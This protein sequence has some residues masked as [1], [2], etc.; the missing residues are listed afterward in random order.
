[1]KR[2]FVGA[3]VL[4]LLAIILIPAWLDGS[5]RRLRDENAFVP[6]QPPADSRKPMVDPEEIGEQLNTGIPKLQQLPKSNPLPIEKQ[7][8][9]AVAASTEKVIPAQAIPVVPVADVVPE[10]IEVDLNA[11]A[12]GGSVAPVE[13]PKN[14]IPV[15]TLQSANWIVQVGSFASRENAES[16]VNRLQKGDLKA[17]MRVFKSKNLSSQTGADKNTTRAV[18]DLYSPL[19]FQVQ[20]GRW[21]LVVK[22]D[23][24][25]QY[26]SPL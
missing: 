16:M 6:P 26:D 22:D 2:R 17:F 19:V 8:E 25:A 5:A 4:V 7:V 18:C 21:P 23:S 15:E 3:L 9:Q 10:P 13:A 24:C 1:V 20:S 11:L 14:V 12:N